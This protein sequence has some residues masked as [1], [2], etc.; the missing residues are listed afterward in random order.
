MTLIMKSIFRG[1]IPFIIMQIIALLLYYQG[2][3][4]DAKS[5][6]FSGLVAFIVGAATVIYNIDQWSLTKQSIVHFLIMLAT[7]YP[8][9]LFSGWFSVS[10]FVDALKVFGVFVLTGLVLWSIMFTLTKIFKWPQLS[11]QV[12]H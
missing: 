3:Y 4:K 9:L 10:T 7:I 8:I 12:Q 1:G 2:Q 6:F 5:T 11:N